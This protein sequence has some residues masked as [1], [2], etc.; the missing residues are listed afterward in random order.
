MLSDENISPDNLALL[1]GL[2]PAK[3]VHLAPAVFTLVSEA[4]SLSIKLSER[5]QDT[6]YYPVLRKSCDLLVALAASAYEQQE[7]T[8]VPLS[9]YEEVTKA[10][11]AVLDCSF[12]TAKRP[13]AYAQALYPLPE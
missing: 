12:T 2:M 8:G 10:F 11:R 3:P 4:I 9:R 5:K 1:K 7:Q 13:A 6:F